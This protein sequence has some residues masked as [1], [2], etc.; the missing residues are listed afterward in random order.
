MLMRLIIITLV[1]GVSVAGCR[2]NPGY[3]GPTAQID[4][5][6][7]AYLAGADNDVYQ[8]G[9]PEDEAIIHA[10]M[11][12][13]DDMAP[14]QAVAHSP[15]QTHEHYPY[16]LDSGDR[17]RLFVYGQPNLSRTYSVDGGGFISVPLIGAVRA[18]NLTTYGL[19]RSIADQLA[20][21]YV[22]DPKVSVEISTYRPFF[23][24]GEVRR[25]G[26]Y[27]FVNAMNVQTAVAIAGGF[28]E[29]AYVKSVKLTR[30]VNGYRTTVKVAPD[31]PVY[32]G[33]TIEVRERFF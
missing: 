25:A 28:S 13:Q 6:E 9:T 19:E 31:T 5:P 8:A 17:L 24:L 11:T 2:P 20:A 29:R 18:R 12:A 3:H 22:R 16:V 4:M 27:P 14:V 7:D 33:D 10:A 21:K 30:I 26:Q 32:R 1:L 15:S 23:I